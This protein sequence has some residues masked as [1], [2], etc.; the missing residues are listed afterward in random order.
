MVLYLQTSLDTCRLDLALL[1]VSWKGMFLRQHQSHLSDRLLC[2]VA[3]F[4]GAHEHLLQPTL[5]TVLFDA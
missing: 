4:A 3:L 1:I 5:D 2:I